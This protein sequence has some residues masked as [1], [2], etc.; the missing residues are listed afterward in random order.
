MAFTKAF[1][2]RVLLAGITNNVPEWT[3][4][5]PDRRLARAGEDG[6]F[7]G[8]YKKNTQGIS[9]HGQEE[10]HESKT[11]R[12]SLVSSR[13]LTSEDGPCRSWIT[14]RT[15]FESLQNRQMD[16]HCRF[17]FSSV[18]LMVTCLLQSRHC[19]TDKINCPCPQIPPRLLTLPPD[20]CFQIDQTFR[21]VCQ[22]GYLRKVG[23]S[24]L[25][26]CK[27]DGNNPPE[28]IPHEPS[29]KCIP[30]PKPQPP[31]STVTT[32]SAHCCSAE[33]NTTTTQQAESTVTTATSSGP[34]TTQKLSPS[35]SVAAEP[36]RPEPT[37]LGL[38]ALPGPSQAA[39]ERVVTETEATLSTSSTAAPLNGSTHNPQAFP[40]AAHTAVG[41]GSLAIVCAS[42]GIGFFCHRRRS[43]SHTLTPEEQMPMN[44]VQSDKET[45]SNSATSQ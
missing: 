44:G 13:A 31:K 10:W 12:R 38:L 11:K 29:L 16:L 39:T 19:S 42:M 41:C 26:K 21:Y 4:A 40:P 25:I 35:P 32:R 6:G 30:D 24:N 2:R 7:L 33:P 5:S 17:A 15:C 20:T 22:E 37:P 23:T 8:S 1:V 43:K 34:Q 14:Q 9:A 27:Q 45:A 28:W 36:D 3:N 18:C